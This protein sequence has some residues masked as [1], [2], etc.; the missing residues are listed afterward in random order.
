M[1]NSKEF[2]KQLKKNNINFYTGVPDS[3][4]SDMCNSFAKFEKNN[5]ELSSNEGSSVGMAIGYHLAT[6]KVPLVYLQNSGLGN[7][8]NPLI[9]LAD[10]KVFNIPIFFLIG[11]RGEIL[12][13]NKQIKDEPQHRTQGLITPKLLKILNIKYRILSKKSN[14]EKDIAYLSKY[15]KQKKR[16]VA[17]L[18]RKESFEKKN[19]NRKSIFKNYLSREKALSEVC[20]H[21]PKKIPKISTTGML[22]RELNEINLKNKTND[23]TFMCVGGMGHAISIATGLAKFK[24]KKKIL[25]LDGD[26]AALMHLGAQAS[27]AKIKNLIHVVFNNAAHDSVDGDRPPSEN[28]N[29]YKLANEMGYNKSFIVKTKREIKS[30]IKFSLKSKKS[31]FIEIICARGHRKNLTRPEKDTIYYKK[32]FMEFLKK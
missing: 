12:K 4:F 3:L 11:W 13:R 25:C 8:I 29:F 16:I 14:F 2:I 22:S 24:R 1:I 10:K 17:L 30:K 31:V 26:G 7:I 28:I 5:H 32:K 6:Q 19:L 23:S 9:S 20:K 15:A 18:I 27:S 21:L